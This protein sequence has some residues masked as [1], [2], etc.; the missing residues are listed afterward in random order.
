MINK[1]KTLMLSLSTLVA[2]AL[3]A[4]MPASVLAANTNI[5][6]GLCQGADINV[7]P[8]PSDAACN[9]SDVSGNN[10]NNKI[11]KIINW[12]S[13]LIG[14]VAVKKTILFAL[15]GLVIVALA[16]LIV[17]FVLQNVNPT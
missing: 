13:A 7:T 2:L 4:V 12:L 16:Q 8:T 1:I 14:V 6:G 5:H 11:A 17:K 9:T 3:P 10:I 15:I